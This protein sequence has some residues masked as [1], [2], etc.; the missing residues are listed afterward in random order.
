M[1]ED[2]LVPR[3]VPW[4]ALALFRV[5]GLHAAVFAVIQ[6]AQAGQGHSI[7]ENLGAM[8]GLAL[9]TGIFSGV[10]FTVLG[11]LTHGL[12]GALKLRFWFI[13]LLA[14][15]FIGAALGDLIASIGMFIPNATGPNHYGATT[16]RWII[17][18]FSGWSGLNALIGWWTWRH[19]GADPGP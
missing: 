2:V 12:L 9:I 13:Y 18:V 16:H 4:F 10:L 7:L 19:H 8:A 14:G 15:L 5:A 3:P 6:L 1:D 17:L 11:G